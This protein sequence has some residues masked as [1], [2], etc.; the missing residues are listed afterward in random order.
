MVGPVILALLAALAG[1]ASGAALAAFVLLKK[2]GKP[3]A[4]SGDGGWAADP[5]LV[6]GHRPPDW[7][8]L[9]S[10]LLGLVKQVLEARGAAL[11]LPRE[12]AWKVA[13]QNPGLSLR[14]RYHLPLKE[15][16]L[17]LAFE[18]EREVAADPVHAQSLGYLEE[19]GEFSVALMPV[20][21][22][23]KVR[24]LIACHRASGRPFQEA[25]MAVLRRC[26]VL[27]DGWEAF[28][29]HSTELGRVRDQEERL[30]R[31][32]DRMLGEKDPMEV[33]ALA[34][35]AVFDILPAVYGFAVIQSSNTNFTALTTKRFEIPDDLHCV[36]RG[37]WAHKCLRERKPLYLEGAVCRDTA[38]PLLCEKEPF[39]AGAPA[40]LVPLEAA[41]ETI[42]VAGVAGKP[43]EGFSEAGREAAR[44]FL[45][46]ASALIS[47]ALLN[48]FNK[49]NAIKDGLTGLYNRRHF[50]ERLS[51]EMRRSQRSSASLGLILIDLDRFKLVNDQHG[52]DA[53]DAVLRAV[54]QAISGA[55][56]SIDVVCR[57]GG[58]EF[59]VIL[60]FCDLSEAA[61]VAERARKAVSLLPGVPQAGVPGPITLSAGVASFPVPFSTPSGLLKAADSALY[62]AKRKGRNRVEIAA[63]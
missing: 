3:E 10:Q 15:G 38:M 37:T 4:S 60:P 1:L 34:L 57:Y 13:L 24:G 51:E 35:D 55:L 53:G 8:A 52:H 56:R 5:S 33:A 47:L 14:P 58:E 32:L 17:G 62:E 45:Q 9:S 7:R 48:Q 41:D 27:L 11:L 63:R 46:Q 44:R 6:D 22:R 26:A 39:A 50:D 36:R 31:G 21:H 16:L 28:A 59:A 49:D 40:L 20:S 19:D 43:S 25:E 12:G 18:G 2:R 30:A 54:A 23:G 42:G 29:A 61:A